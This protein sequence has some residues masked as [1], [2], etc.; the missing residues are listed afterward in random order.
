MICWRGQIDADRLPAG[1]I[2]PDWSGGYTSIFALQ[3]EEERTEAKPQPAM[4]M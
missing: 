4:A 3:Q 1:L 2:P